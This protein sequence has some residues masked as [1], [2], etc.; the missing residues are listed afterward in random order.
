MVITAMKYNR[1]ETLGKLTDRPNVK[2]CGR[3]E[4]AQVI[5]S[6]NNPGASGA[7]QAEMACDQK[8]VT[9]TGGERGCIR[10]SSEV[11]PLAPSMAQYEGPEKPHIVA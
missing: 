1:L 6:Q 3:I 7:K 2:V 4:E 11:S 8:H 10:L 9:P 5:E